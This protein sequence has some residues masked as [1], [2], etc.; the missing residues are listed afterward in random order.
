MSAEFLTFN[1]RSCSKGALTPNR[2]D[3]RT[4][5]RQAGINCL[6]YNSLLNCHQELKF[7]ICNKYQ[8]WCTYPVIPENQQQSRVSEISFFNMD[9]FLL[10]S[11]WHW[12]MPTECTCYIYFPNCAL[13]VAS[14]WWKWRLIMYLSKANRHMKMLY[15]LIL[16]LFNIYIFQT[17]AKLFVII[18]YSIL[19]SCS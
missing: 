5:V 3:V 6:L 4:Y 14:K 15:Y 17:R 8:W 11:E 2:T 9:W 12:F 7:G 18:W 10:T 19:P 1:F 13:I 16:N